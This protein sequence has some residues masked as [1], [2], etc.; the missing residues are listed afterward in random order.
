MMTFTKIT[1]MRT[2][3]KNTISKEIMNSIVKGSRLLENRAG[4]IL[5]IFSQG[6]SNGWQDRAA[7]FLSEKNHSTGG[8]I[9]YYFR[10][11]F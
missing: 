1:G 6:N 2:F 8:K 5:P 11:D 4:L 3:T 9:L 10:F 7:L